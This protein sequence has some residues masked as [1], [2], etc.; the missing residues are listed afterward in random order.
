[1][2]PRLLD[3]FEK[4]L[5]MEGVLATR[6]GLH[7]GA[8]ESGDPLATDSPVVRDATG[9]PFVP[10]SSLKGVVRS[11][12][13][14]LLRGAGNGQNGSDRLWTC[15]H[16]ANQP[17]VSHEDL[18]G[19]RD[20]WQDHSRAVAEAIWA[21]SCTVCRL[22]GSLALAS[23]VRFPDLPLAGGA[24]LLELR[25]GVGIDRDKELA[26]AGVLYDFEAV[27]PETPFR[28]TVILDNY[29]DWEVG[30]LLYL[31]EQLDQGSLALGGKTSRGL[32]QVR[33][34][35]QTMAETRL[36]KDNPFAELLSTRDLLQP[37]AAPEE[38]A[39]PIEAAPPI[40]ASGNP[41][42]WKTLAEILSSMPEIDKGAL[43]QLAGQQGFKKLEL[44]DRLGLGLEGKRVRKAWDTV[45]E[46]FVESGFLTEK[47]GRFMI[48]G[49]ELEEPAPEEA[50][51]PERDPAL[52]KLYD[53]YVQAMAKKWEESD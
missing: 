27:P 11:A 43:G 41:E 42:D 36:D 33:I 49:S 31:F 29:D 38:E 8:G 47:D 3:T 24:P 22:F 37:E 48:A 17:C 30:L 20:R 13:E 53:R 18:T 23:R 6:T 50:T 46:R 45:L 1:M 40:P 39:E 35:W 9:V 10:G 44:N 15:D 2:T 16:I 51:A 25:N 26:A 19:I 5:R 34:D 7:I 14:S 32:G 21:R 52:Q 4:R 12:T 28:L